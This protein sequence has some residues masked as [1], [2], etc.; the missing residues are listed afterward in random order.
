MLKD[1]VIGLLNAVLPD[2]WQVGFREAAGGYVDADEA[3]W[4][5]LS[6]SAQR[7]LAPVTHSRMLKVAAYLWEQ[8]PLANRL[9]EVPLAYVLAEGVTLTC[10]DEDNQA[11]LDAFWRDPINE[12]DIKL[13]K[14]VRELALFG[15][16]CYPVFVD[17]V[18]GTVRLA[19]LDPTHIER[20]VVDPDN[21][22]QVIGIETTRDASGRYRRL[23]VIINGPESVFS[24][25]TQALRQAMTDGECFFFRI[26]DL[27]AGRRGRSDLL[28][29]AD[30]CDAY[31]EMLFGEVERGK[32]LR[33]FF[34]D[35]TLA[36]A[37]PEQ[38]K[39]RSKDITAPKPGAVRVHNE[40]E[41]WKAE[42]PDLK[43]AD[44]AEGARTLRNHVLGGAT[45]PEHW[46]GGGGDVNRSTGDS[47]SEPTMKMLTMRQRQV[48][49]MLESIGR[50][51]LTVKARANNTKPD[52]AKPEWKVTCNMPE[53]TAK[54]TSKYA[55]ALQQVVVAVGLAVDRGFLTE[56]T[57]VKMIASIANMMGVE[58]DAKAELANARA[59]LAEKRAADAFSAPSG[60]AMPQDNPGNNAP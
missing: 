46:F 23:R 6:G 1:H 35:V 3:N 37:T 12:M 51:V 43:A 47:M 52:C 21:I 44:T 56:E 26:N 22:E 60:D 49:H 9:I 41:V 24:R 10:A 15:E 59:A 55:Q 39:A 27:C 13:P 14:K 16:Q 50:F 2:G 54:D 53:L 17:E 38:V 28:A 57:A 18:A 5:P 7:D 33:A 4:R 42:T 31:E 34:W 36:N 32:A 19:Y 30:W 40:A 45:V 11:A 8:N 58:V 20:V 29:L 25:R 48:K